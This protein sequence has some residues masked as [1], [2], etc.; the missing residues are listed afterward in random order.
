LPRATVH[1]DPPGTRP[2]PGITGMESRLWGSALPDARATVTLDGYVVD[3]VA[4]PVAYAFVVGGRVAA[5][6]PTPGDAGAPPVRFRP[7]RRGD[8]DVVEYVVWHG[9]AHVYAPAWGLDFGVQDLG[10]VT[11]PERA[12]YHVA[13]IRALLR[14]RGLG[15]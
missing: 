13:E 4:H 11:V 10:T 9:L 8:T 1:A 2:W 3:V 5:L 12:P 14:S 7:T 6:G 15:S